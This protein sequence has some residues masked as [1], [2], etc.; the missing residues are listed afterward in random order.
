MLELGATVGGLT[1]SAAQHLGLPVGVPVAQGGAD[2]FVGML[3][4]GVVNPNQ[5]AL[6]TG[7]SHLLLGLAAERFHAKGL[8]GTCGG[9][10]STGSHRT[11][12]VRAPGRS[13]G[14]PCP[15]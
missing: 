8:F 13:R 12:V 10:V 3:G 5:L 14:S 9:H 7:S 2:A 11:E 6:I 4:L 1:V 15:L